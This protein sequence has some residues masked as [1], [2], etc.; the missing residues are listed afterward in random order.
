MNEKHLLQ[1]ELENQKQSF[2]EKF[3]AAIVSH[4]EDLDRLVKKIETREAI[5]T[6]EKQK[7][8]SKEIEVAKSHAEEILR[9]QNEYESKLLVQMQENAHKISAYQCQLD[10]KNLVLNQITLEHS[11]ILSEWKKQVEEAEN[12]FTLSVKKLESQHINAAKETHR[13]YSK[14]MRCLEISM[15]MAIDVKNKE[16]DL[17]VQEYRVMVEEVKNLLD[18]VY[19]K[20]VELQRTTAY[21]ATLSSRLK[22]M[23]EEIKLL[24][25]ENDDK[26]SH[27]SQMTTKYKDEFKKNE[28]LSCKLGELDTEVIYL[29]KDLRKKEADWKKV[30]EDY[31]KTNRLC[32]KLMNEKDELQKETLELKD[33]INKML[34]EFTES[35]SILEKEIKDVNEEVK[36]AR[37]QC[38]KY[39]IA[40]TNTSKSL[41]ALRERLIENE[42]DVE[43]LNSEKS[44]LLKALANCN[45]ENKELKNNFQNI[46]KSKIDLESAVDEYLKVNTNLK[47]KCCSLELQWQESE[48]KIEKLSKANKILESDTQSRIKMIN[49]I[50]KKQEFQL[51]ETEKAS[52]DQVQKI[53]ETLMD[54]LESFMEFSTK[55]VHNL[56]TKIK[57]LKAVNHEISLSLKTKTEEYE[58]LFTDYEILKTTVEISRNESE[59]I[60][61]TYEEQ[62]LHLKKLEKSL[63]EVEFEKEEAERKLEQKENE[64][65]TLKKDYETVEENIKEKISLLESQEEI[66]ARLENEVCKKKKNIKKKP[67]K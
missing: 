12:S 23:L 33:K 44:E 11:K 32:D 17:L 46:L 65:S 37:N 56:S 54:R 13:R 4:E 18:C 39:E 59:D 29:Q 47:E 40:M 19:Q 48:T 38:R 66:K 8:E 3:N 14:K 45:K 53:S 16:L 25:K 6:L 42:K 61:K 63:E 58:N 64:Y 26:S 31:T 67:K 20:E 15:D 62:L 28:L 51:I 60:K 52:L 50:L 2:E 27:L 55:N 1:S 24:N 41:E 22:I 21:N 49:D 36:N 5:C 7:S 43:Q 57:D 9:L 30:F 10:E 35:K 34:E